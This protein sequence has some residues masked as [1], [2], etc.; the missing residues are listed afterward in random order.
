M[1]ESPHPKATMFKLS[2]NSKDPDEP[3]Q[4][5]RARRSSSFLSFLSPHP[6]PLLSQPVHG[7]REVLPVVMKGL[8]HFLAQHVQGHVTAQCHLCQLHIL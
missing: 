2:Q 1:K 4:L 8:V 3:T 6:S 5:K 7:E